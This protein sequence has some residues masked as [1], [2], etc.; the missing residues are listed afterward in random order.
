MACLFCGKD[1]G[2]IRLIRDREF[3]SPKHRKQYKDR[4]Q[5]VL[6]RVGEPETVP[7]GMAPFEDPVRPLAGYTGSSL[8]TF[9]FSTSP[10]RTHVPQDWT[11]EIPEAGGGVFAK[12]SLTAYDLAAGFAP[13]RHEPD[14]LP[15]FGKNARARLL[16]LPPAPVQAVRLRSLQGSLLSPPILLDYRAPDSAAHAA[17]PAATPLS[18]PQARDL[19]LPGFA[20]PAADCEELARAAEPHAEPVPK[21]VEAWMPGPALQ[22]A[23]VDARP[24][25][26]GAIPAAAFLRLP[27]ALPAGIQTP[28]PVAEEAPAPAHEHWMPSPRPELVAG[29]ALPAVAGALPVTPALRQPLALTAQVPAPRPSWNAQYLPGPAAAALD[30]P[31]RLVAS[32][33]APIAFPSA[34]PNLTALAIPYPALPA[35][36]GHW[37]PV[38]ESEPAT[39]DVRPIAAFAP[40]GLAGAPLNFAPLTLVAVRDEVFEQAPAEEAPA[41][42]ASP[43]KAAAAPPRPAAPKTPILVPVEAT[44]AAAHR[45]TPVTAP[46]TVL[47]FPKLAAQQAMPQAPTGDFDSQS[48]EA[49]P[50]GDL[51][52]V[53]YHCQTGPESPLAKLHWAKRSLGVELPRFAV[54]P[55][56]DRLEDLAPPKKERKTP[57][58]AEIFSMPDAAALVKRKATRHAITAIAASVTVAMAL[59][60]GANAGKLGRDMLSRDTSRDVASSIG[61]SGLSS[62]GGATE[63]ASVPRTPPSPLSSPVAWVKVKAAQRAAV[64]VGD[65]FASGMEAWGAKAKSFAPGWSRNTDGYVHPGQLALF[66]PTLHF[67]DYR[68]EFFGQIESKSLSWVVRGKDPK[69]YYAMK[70]NVVQPGLRPIIS[71][72]HYPVVDGRAGQKVEMPLS[73]MV[74]N[75][76]P[77]HVAVDVKGSHFVASIEGQEVDEW[78]DDSLMAGGVGFFS[79]A[80]ARARIY[81]MKVSKNDDWLGHICGYLSGGA[82]IP[83]TAWL[84]RPEIPVPAP[85]RPLPPPSATAVWVAEMDAPGFGKPQRGKA[86]LKGGIETWSS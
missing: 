39:R 56:F 4:L 59:W 36:T 51:L 78:T 53:E 40:A 35:P 9:D 14:A 72:V 75:D 7:V 79:E 50:Y 65:T 46:P 83:E 31:A 25:L 29:M 24:S 27:E 73:V 1:I 74:H 52:T 2:P 19:A 28:Q 62:G 11:V 48:L 68:M 23:A 37:M 82:E 8:A 64:Q 21:P 41:A 42:V 20:L 15:Y 38:P 44:P 66:Q 16:A 57:G 63:T 32:A 30:V 55:I 76:T 84:E 54:R 70:F 47:R 60:F 18:A 49:V 33:A 81:W 58:F 86:S 3:C 5:K 45:T 26:T 13:R 43:T 22:P 12:F 6:V 17:K 10:H 71:M 85:E 34:A 69:N 61:S 80:G 77:Y 67:T